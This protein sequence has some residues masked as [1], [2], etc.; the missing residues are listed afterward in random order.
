MVKTNNTIAIE[1]DG[2]HN[3]QL[4]F[5]PLQ[6]SIR[7]RF[8]LNRIREPQARMKTTEWPE[9]IPSQRIGIDLD[10]GTGFIVETI[11][12][13]PAIKARIEQRGM[14]LAPEREEFSNVDL[15]TWLYWIKQ[16]VESGLAKVVV[17][18]LPERIEGEPQ[19]EFV[20]QRGPDTN[21]RL[22]AAIESNTAVLSALL[23]KLT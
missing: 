9:P 4:R 12:Q 10:S 1:I 6:R 11:H 17:G 18:E 5:R 20:V 16:A 21:D 23:E 7:G 22:A 15:P 8:D 13:H 2:A 3:E 14:Q 19:M